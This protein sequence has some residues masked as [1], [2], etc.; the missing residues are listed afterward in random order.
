MRPLAVPGQ[1]YLGLVE[2][3]FDEGIRHVSEPLENGEGLL[4]MEIQVPG[5]LEEAGVFPWLWL[6]NSGMTSGGD[7]TLSQCAS[8]VSLAF[9]A[10]SFCDFN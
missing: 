2:L 5:L 8:Y 6:G 1:Q 4:R 10:F 9:A 3:A 7:V